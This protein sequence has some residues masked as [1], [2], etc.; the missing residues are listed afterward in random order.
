MSRVL[1]TGIGR[2]GTGY[3][4]RVLSECGLPCGHERVFN[5]HT[6]DPD[7]WGS[8]Q[9]ESSWLAVPWLGRL[10][11]EDVLVYQLVR[12]PLRWLDSWVETVFSDRRYMNWLATQLGHQP[13]WWKDD[14]V[15]AAQELWLRRF[16]RRRVCHS[17]QSASKPCSTRCP[18]T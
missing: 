12:D 6:K 3:M 15:N 9:A 16:A 10:L 18:R 8:R 14:P 17:T 2:S 7:D 11:T 1:I 13:H 5:L 4:A